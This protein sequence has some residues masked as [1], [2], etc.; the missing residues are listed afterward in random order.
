[1]RTALFQ[2]SHS[3]HKADKPFNG[4]FYCADLV[5]KLCHE[6]S[7]ISRSAVV[8]FTNSFAI[9][10]LQNWL[11]WKFLVHQIISWKILE[12]SR[13]Y[14]PF[15]F[16]C[17]TKHIANVLH[18]MKIYLFYWEIYIFPSKTSNINIYLFYLREISCILI[19]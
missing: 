7:T 12:A 14:K 5:L 1:M 17:H 15:K 2:G 6:N 13:R 18:L 9:I 19:G 3:V 4:Y 8:F 16:V 10:K 11:H